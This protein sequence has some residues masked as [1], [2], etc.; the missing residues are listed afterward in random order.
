MGIGLL[1]MLNYHLDFKKTFYL[2]YFDFFS[3]RLTTTMFSHSEKACHHPFFIHIFFFFLYF[4]LYTMIHSRS[5][6]N[7][8][9]LVQGTYAHNFIIVLLVLSICFRSLF[10]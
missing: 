7:E 9:T 10:A 8:R 6:W 4:V 2:A 1:L 3:N 5:E